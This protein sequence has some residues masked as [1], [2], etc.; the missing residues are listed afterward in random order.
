ML[1]KDFGPFPFSSIWPM[2]SFGREM[3]MGILWDR[4]FFLLFISGRLIVLSGFGR[5]ASN[6]RLGVFLMMSIPEK[7][8]KFLSINKLNLKKRLKKN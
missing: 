4:I 8:K 2:Q 7:K 6:V 1:N 3:I 5:Y